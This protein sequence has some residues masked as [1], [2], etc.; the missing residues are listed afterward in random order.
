MTLT[1]ERKQIKRKA[2][3][4]DLKGTFPPRNFFFFWSVFLGY[5]KVGWQRRVGDLGQAD[6]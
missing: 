1:F 4:R 5:L 2:L 3:Q 6:I